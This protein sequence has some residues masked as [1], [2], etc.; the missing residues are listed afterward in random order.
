MVQPSVA[1]YHDCRRA[2]ASGAFP[3]KVRVTFKVGNRWVVKYYPTGFA[4][5]P[6][7]WVRIRSDTVRDELRSIREKIMARE[8]EAVEIIKTAPFMKEDTFTA[9]F[10]GI[11]T[12]SAMIK[13]LFT[14]IALKKLENGHISSSRLFN[15]ALKS[16]IQYGGEELTLNVIDKDFLSGFEGWMRKPRMVDKEIIKGKSAST[17]GIYLR[18]LRAVFN[19]AMDRGIISRDIYPFG[20]KRYV[21]PSSRRVKRAL[22]EADKIK[23]ISY[24]PERPRQARALELWTFSYYC[25][26]MNFTDMAY[27]KPGNVQ[28]DLLH[29][30]RRK[31]ITTERETL[32]QT[33]TLRKEVLAILERELKL[34]H[35]YI[36]G[37]IKSSDSPSVQKDKINYWTSYTNR[38]LAMI[39]RDIGIPRVTTYSARHTAAT[40]L[41]RAGADMKYIQDRLGHSSIVTTQGYIASLDREEQRKWTATL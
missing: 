20:R 27:L 11:Q 17:I 23:L 41:L 6:D 22:S 4:V 21:I 12:R 14:E 10:T 18:N 29:Y 19:I 25:D 28:G 36:F 33:V 30:V 35:E 2:N 16:L 38:R 34:G 3:V 15:N 40:M 31:S 37:V 32:H 7:E 8:S 24:D 13:P 39:C 9:I 26:G 5:M 1:L